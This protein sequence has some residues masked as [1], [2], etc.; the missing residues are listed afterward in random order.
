MIRI[1]AIVED[2]K[3]SLWIGT[4]GS[5]DLYDRKNDLFISYDEKDGFPNNVIMG[6]LRRQ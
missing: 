4:K 3:G 1:Y 2:S 6:I 5:L